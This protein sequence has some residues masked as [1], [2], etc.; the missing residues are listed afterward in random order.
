[1]PIPYRIGTTILDEIERVYDDITSRAYQVGFH[2]SGAYTLNIED[3][4]TA[5]KQMVRKPGA[6]LIEKHGLFIVKVTLEDVEPSAVDILVTT[7]DVLIQSNAGSPQPRIFR[8]VHFPSPIN[9][10]GLH[11]TYVNRKLILM[12]PKLVIR[13]AFEPVHA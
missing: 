5:E 10:M 13:N 4:L 2:G 7:D 11:A 1:M 6:D 8:A 3:W 12:A 9:P